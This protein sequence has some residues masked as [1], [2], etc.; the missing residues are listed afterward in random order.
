MAVVALYD[1]NV[2]YGNTL[3]DM[4]IRLAQSDL[5]EARWTDMILDEALGSVARKYPDIPQAKLDR[6]RRLTVDA[7]PKCLVKGFEPLIEK[8]ELPDPDD[9]HV[10]AA[11]ITAGA[12]TIVTFNLADFPADSLSEWSVTAKSPDSF[13]VDLIDRDDQIVWA[14]VLQIAASHRNPPETTGDVLNNLERAGLF[15]SVALLRKKM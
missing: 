13:L 6:V 14:C 1:A 12:K 10:L 9:R 3:R 5:V 8:L 11:A 7:V 15:E 2:L 4:M